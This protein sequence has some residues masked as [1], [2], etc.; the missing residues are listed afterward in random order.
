[1]N[2]TIGIDPDLTL[3]GVATY[4][5]ETRELTVQKLSFFKLLEYLQQNREQIFRVRIEAGWLVNK[6]NYHKQ[7]GYKQ[8]ERIA[9]NVGENHA[10]GKMIA[11][12][13]QYLELDFELRKPLK[14]LWNGSGGKISHKE[15]TFQ[16]S[17]IKIPFK[18]RSN[19]EERDAV[20][21]CL[22]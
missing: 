1:M 13:C 5:K 15:L 6:S 3:S 9:K 4:N 18:T 19:Q 16:L 22:Y 8:R 20:L 2:L 12:M 11:E 14:K 17:R 21:I 7:Q 10:I